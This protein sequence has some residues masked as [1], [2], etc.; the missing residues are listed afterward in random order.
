[1]HRRTVRQAIGNAVPP[2]RKTPVREA[3]ALGRWA[4]TIRGWLTDDL[5]MP[6]PPREGYGGSSDGRW[7][8]HGRSVRHCRPM[9]SRPDSLLRKAL[10]L[11]YGTIVWNGG[12]AVFT[13]GLGIAAGSLALIGFGTD[14]LIEI[15]ASLVVVWHLKGEDYPDRE[16]L[17]LRLIAVAFITLAVILGIAGVRDLLTG[18]RAD[19]SIPGIIYL[20]LTAVVM[21]GLSIAKRRIADAMDSSTLRS[22]ATMT[23]LDGILSAGTMLGLALNAGL[24]W[25]WADPSAALIVAIAAFNE[26]RKAWP[27]T[28][29]TAPAVDT[30]S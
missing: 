13:I 2:V 15:F 11:E 4:E 24:G 9:E 20:G 16:R 10:R 25:W 23:Y 12:E 21:F 30:L 14:S 19:E 6:A 28:A 26:G 27:K 29:E 22:E 18:R 17:A 3:P 1:M 5:E 8:C 7:H